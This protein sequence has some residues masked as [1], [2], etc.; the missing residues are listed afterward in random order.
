MQRYTVYLYLETA[1]HVLGS[2]STHHQ[3]RIQLYLQDLLF[4][5]TPLLLSA[6]IVEELE[7]VWVCCGWRTPPTGHSNRFQLF[8]DSKGKPLTTLYGTYD[9][10]TCYLHVSTI[11]WAW[12]PQPPRNMCGDS[13]TFDLRGCGPIVLHFITYT[14]R[15]DFKEHR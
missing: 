2:T 1:V 9:W 4:V 5:T 14:I 7:P 10:Q 13:F 15:S 6:A 12:E 3:E 11:W 8:H